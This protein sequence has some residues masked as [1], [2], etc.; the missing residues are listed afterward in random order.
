MLNVGGAEG[1]SRIRSKKPQCVR[2]AGVHFVDRHLCCELH[3]V[4]TTGISSNWESSGHACRS[5]ANWSSSSFKLFC[6]TLLC[7]C[8]RLDT[9]LLL[10]FFASHCSIV[11]ARYHVDGAG[12]FVGNNMHAHRK[13]QVSTSQ[14]FETTHLHCASN[15]W[16]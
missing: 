12:T 7:Y 11:F 3:N 6:F 9:I 1:V 4:F 15:S 10:I 13:R 2:C 8:A 16:F 14:F 5:S